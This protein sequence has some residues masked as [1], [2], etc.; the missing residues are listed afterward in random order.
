MDDPD[1][2]MLKLTIHRDTIDCNY[3]DA[4]SS[5]PDYNK[6][7]KRFSEKLEHNRLSYDTVK[8]LI[9]Q[10][11]FLSGRISEQQIQVDSSMVGELVRILGAH[12]YT[13][14]FKGK[15]DGCLMEALETN[16][17]KLIRVELE[18]EDQDL[19]SWPWEYLYNPMD[20]DMPN[21]GDF[22][23]KQI[24]LVLNR[25]LYLDSPPLKLA[26]SRPVK[27]LF[28]V[29]QPKD[30]GEVDYAS[31]YSAIKQM[32]V[33][34]VVKLREL[35]DVYE[36]S[37]DY[38]PKVTRV[39]FPFHVNDFKPNIIHFIGHGE[40]TKGKGGQ[41]VM[42]KAGGE[43][44]PVSDETFARWLMNKRDLKLVFLQACESALPDP[45]H[46]TSGMALQLAAMNIPAVVAMQYKVKNEIANAFACSFYKALE[47][48]L[49][50]DLAVKAGRDAIGVNWSDEPQ[51]HAFGLPVLYLRSYE[52]V[53]LPED[54]QRQPAGSALQSAPTT[55]N[56]PRAG[57]NDELS[58]KCPNL[59]CET[60]QSSNNIFCIKCGLLL[61]CG[62]EWC[63]SPIDQPLIARICNTCGGSLYCREKGCKEPVI[64]KNKADNS[65]YCELHKPSEKLGIPVQDTYK[66]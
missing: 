22:L 23:V 9:E 46:S 31:T 18:F 6:P 50:V 57:Q 43:A 55:L 59:D 17:V 39:E 11:K 51:I 3:A 30:W 44:D 40:S 61:R 16:D 20:D 26:T 19:A 64:I 52:T 33:N 32:E 38:K 37:A 34:G 41:I 25:K 15:I 10:L 49:S 36:E 35:I 65:N 14:L 24:Q 42:V 48:G 28:V 53:I 13:V 1:V 8:F 27:I 12:L 4:K 60:E 66:R 47:N 58:R 7:R 45:Y 63:N 62:R 56:V 54:K 21:T 2:K 5:D 29:S